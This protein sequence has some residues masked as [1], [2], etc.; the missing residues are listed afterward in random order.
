MSYEL[1]K[2]NDAETVL[3]D[4][5]DGATALESGTLSGTGRK[6]RIRQRV[7]GAYLGLKIG[8]SAADETWAVEVIVG[9]VVP[10]GK[11]K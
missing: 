1:H 11:L 3:E 2:G 8:N 9:E 10:A 7:R 4:I 6:E 5:I